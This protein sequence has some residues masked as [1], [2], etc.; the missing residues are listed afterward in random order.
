M[1]AKEHNVEN[2]LNT[3][4]SFILVLE[5]YLELREI[6]ALK[7]LVLLIHTLLMERSSQFKLHAN[8]LKMQWRPQ[9]WRRNI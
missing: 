2:S 5:T 9:A 7:L 1:Q 6:V 8:L 4:A 3:L